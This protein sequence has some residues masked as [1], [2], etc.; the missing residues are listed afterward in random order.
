MNSRTDS[1]LELASLAGTL[2]L[3]CGGETSRAEDTVMHIF[4]AAG[5]PRSQVSCQ[6][7][8]V[9]LTLIGDGIRVTTIR[10]VGPRSID[11]SA[12]KAVN[13]ISRAFSE[14]RVIAEE[15]VESLN[16]S[17][18]ETGGIT[19]KKALFSAMA[20][21]LSVAAF[22]VMFGG[23]LTDAAVAALAGIIVSLLQSLLSGDGSGFIDRFIV[24]MTGGAVIGGIVI[25]AGEVL[26][27]ASVEGV[28]VG[29]IMP[30]LPG[31]ALT[32]SI[33]DT[34]VGDLVSGVARLA[35]V[36]M[37]GFALAGGMGAALY[38]YVS[39]SGAGTVGGTFISVP[40][41][42]MVMIKLLVSGFIAT[43]FYQLL[44]NAP[45]TAVIPAAL[46]GGATYGLYALLETNGQKYLGY[47]AATLFAAAL[48]E[49][50]ARRMKMPSTIF[51]FPGLVPLVP[52]MGLYE[53]MLYIVRGRPEEALRLGAE[54]M[55]C[56]ALMAFAAAAEGA[57][58]GRIRKKSTGEQP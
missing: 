33:R 42:A 23:T 7:T 30:L 2:I 4:T 12:L 55:I 25:I 22:S 1:V 14:N 15:A 49:I 50:L 8:A 52:G 47:F 24:G 6:P 45:K 13:D 39:L 31:L 16:R 19:L 44:W 20:A 32:V 11:L 58:T 18:V 48:S 38:L 35:E 57:V 54:V 37:T 17:S 34:I 10:R 26:G 46:I 40:M 9:Y 5:Y 53:T 3:R 41:S 21:A 36:I 51:L 29:A 43:A 56:A 27:I 28:I